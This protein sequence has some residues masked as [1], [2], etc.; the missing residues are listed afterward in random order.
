MR[1]NV[2]AAGLI[3]A[4]FA[5]APLTAQATMAP[6]NDLPNPYRTIEGWAKLPDGRIP[7]GSTS[8]VAS[9]AMADSGGGMSALMGLASFDV[10][11]PYVPNDMIAQIHKGEAIV[12]AHLNSTNSSVSVVNQF[13]LPGGADLRTQ[14]QI[15]A[16]AGAG[17]Q[18]ALRRNG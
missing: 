17:I 7:W 11:T 2:R 16:M 18:A 8:A 13:S 6:V 5:A 14:S 1:W 4:V 3:M 12:P 15:A 10:G 9:G